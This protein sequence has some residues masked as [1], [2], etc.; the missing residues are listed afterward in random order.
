MISQFR[1][2]FPGIRLEMTFLKVS[3]SFLSLI[4]FLYRLR[5]VTCPL[6][7]LFIFLPFPLCKNRCCPE[8]TIL[9]MSKPFPFV[10]R[11]RPRSEDAVGWTHL[12]MLMSSY[13]RHLSVPI[14]QSGFPF[15]YI[16]LANYIFSSQTFFFVS[17]YLPPFYFCDSLSK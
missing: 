13:W 1:Q 5:Y 2:D 9:S 8:K 15:I 7:F 10:S 17:F 4:G 14:C 16:H 6:P 11:C 12:L 3:R